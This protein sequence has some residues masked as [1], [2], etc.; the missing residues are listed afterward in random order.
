MKKRATF[1]EC[2]ICADIPDFKALERTESIEH[3]E[4]GLEILFAEYTHPDRYMDDSYLIKRCVNCGTFYLQYHSIDTEDAFVGGPRITHE[5]QRFNLYRLKNYFKNFNK[6]KEL[7]DLEMQYPS[8]IKSFI[9]YIMHNS[10]NIRSN[11]LKY[12]IESITDYFVEKSDW[13]ELNEILL[14]HVDPMIV[15]TAAH[16]LILMYAGLSIK[17]PYPP[18]AHYKTISPEL[19]DKF[20]P[21]FADH[22]EEFKECILKY[23]KYDDPV[24]KSSFESLLKTAKYYKVL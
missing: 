8:Q 24:I 4:E 13:N 22:L 9:H 14:K 16:D 23:A 1:F 20:K 21:L 18:F 5:I 6:T 17:G 3:H 7:A 10:L 12:I 11:H 19:Q 15:L 2:G